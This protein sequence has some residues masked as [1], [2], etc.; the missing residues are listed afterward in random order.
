MEVGVADVAHQIAVGVVLVV[1]LGR[2]VVGPV[3]VAVAVGVDVE[4]VV[5]G[6]AVGV[7]RVRG[8]V[9]VA[10]LDAVDRVLRVV[11]TDAAVGVQVDVVLE[12]VA[13]VVEGRGQGRDR[14]RAVRGDRALGLG[15]R[16]AQH[17]H[18]ADVALAGLALGALVGV[19]DGVGVG[20]G[21]ERVDEQV[22]V[23]VELIDRRDLAHGPGVGLLGAV[24]DAVGVGVVVE[25]GL[26]AVV[27][28]IA[29]DVRRLLRFGRI[30]DLRLVRPLDRVVDAVGVGVEVVVVLGQVLVAVGRRA[31]RAAVVAAVARAVR[32]EGQ[33]GQLGGHLVAVLVRVE[34]AIGVGVVVEVVGHGVGV[35]VAG[36]VRP[37]DR[38]AGLAGVAVLVGHAAHVALVRVGDAVVVGVEVEEV[39]VAVGVGVGVGL[40][41]VGD[42]VVVRVAVLVV[43]GAVGPADLGGVVVVGLDVVEDA[44]TVGVVVEP[45]VDGVV[46]GTRHALGRV[47]GER[48]ALF[49]VEDAVAVGV[50]VE[51][52]EHAVAVA[53]ATQGGVERVV[54]LVALAAHGGQRAGPRAAVLVGVGDGVAVGVGVEPVL[55]RVAVAVVLRARAAQA[56]VRGLGGVLVLFVVEHAVAVGVDVLRVDVAVVVAVFVGPAQVGRQVDA[57]GR[58]VAHAG[59]AGRERGQRRAAVGVGAGLVGVGEAV[60]VGVVVDPVLVVVV[61]AVDARVADAAGQGR[62]APLLGAV[63][64]RGVAAAV[65]V[66]GVVGDAVVVRVEVEGVQQLVGG[67]AVEVAGV[68]AAAQAVVR[69][70]VVVVAR[71]VGVGDPVVVGVEI[72]PV[73]DAVGVDVLAAGLDRVAGDAVLVGVEDAVVVGVEVEG[74]ERTVAIGVGRDLA[75]VAHRAD[76]GQRVARGALVGRP[77]AR[78]AGR[79]VG[80][81]LVDVELAVAVGVV[82]VPALLAVGAGLEVGGQG[83]GADRAVPLDVVEHAVVV[84]VEVHGAEVR[85]TVKVLRDRRAARAVLRARE[86]GLVRIGDAV[87]VGVG[88]DPVLVGVGVAVVLGAARVADGRREL[89]GVLVL[90]VVEDPVAVGVVVLRVDLVVAVEVDLG[91]AGHGGHAAAALVRVGDAVAVGLEVDEGADAVAGAA[92]VA[93]VDLLDGVEDAVGVGVEILPVI[94]AVVVA[95]AGDSRAG[96]VFAR[97]GV[98]LADRHDVLDGVED[99]VAVHVV[100]DVVE[101]RVEVEVEVVVEVQA[102]LVVDAREVGDGVAVGVAVEPVPEVVVVDVVVAF[103]V[104]PDVVGVGVAVVV[105]QEAVAVTVVVERRRRVEVDVGVALGGQEIVLDEVGNFVA[106][107]VGVVAADE[108]RRGAVVEVLLGRTDGAEFGVVVARQRV[109]VQIGHAVVVVVEVALVAVA[110]AIVVDLRGVGVD[111]GLV[112][113]PRGGVGGAGAAVAHVADAV[114]V[115]VGLGVVLGGGRELSGH[116]GRADL[117]AEIDRLLVHADLQAGGRRGAVVAAV[118]QQVVV[119]VGLA[120]VAGQLAVVAVPAAAVAVAVDRVAASEA[121]HARAVLAAGRLVGHDERRGVLQVA[122]GV[123]RVLDADDRHGRVALVGRGRRVDQDVGVGARRIVEGRRRG[124]EAVIEDAGAGGVDA[125]EGERERAVGVHGHGR[126]DLRAGGGDVARL[127]SGAH[128]REVAV[129]LG[130]EDI[131]DA[132]VD[133]LVGNDHVAGGLGDAHVGRALL[134]DFVARGLVDRHFAGRVGG[135]VGR[136]LGGEDVDA[137]TDV[138]GVP[139]DR[140]PSARVHGDARGLLGLGGRRVD[141]ELVRGVAVG[142][143]PAREDAVAV[144]ARLVEG[145]PRHDEVARVVHGDIGRALRARRELVD[146]QLDADLG[147]RLVEAL[148]AD[149]LVVHAVGPH[150]DEAAVGVVR[151]GGDLRQLL[152]AGGSRRGE[153]AVVEVD[154]AAGVRVERVLSVQQAAD[155]DVLGAAL[156]AREGHRACAAGLVL[157][158][159][160]RA[161]GAGVVVDGLDRAIARDVEVEL[162]A[163]RGLVHEELGGVGRLVLVGRPRLVGRTPHVRRHGDR[164]R[165][166][167]DLRRCGR[168]LESVTGQPLRGEVVLGDVFGLRTGH[169]CQRHQRREQEALRTVPHR[170]P[171]KRSQVV[172]PFCK[173]RTGKASY[174]R[175]RSAATAFRGLV[176]LA[177]PGRRRT[178]FRPDNFRQAG[179]AATNEGSLS[180]FRSSPSFLILGSRTLR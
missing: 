112:G 130:E 18:A 120:H 25:P 11:A 30:L 28:D 10:G 16:V 146:G 141:A 32:A 178:F 13:V 3:L 69:R 165:G 33:R 17:A 123:L 158:G 172:P 105:V 101:E 148:G 174:V 41:G 100:V 59:V 173:M 161:D 138:R 45:G 88:V 110:V 5:L 68:G 170:F 152:V 92:V 36:Q 71:L 2:A 136:E 73:P 177:R 85:V 52:V 159:L 99:A 37:G 163:V 179:V 26:E 60:A 57:A 167:D 166:G 129:E 15:R 40:G 65:H 89:V 117:G 72:P 175:S 94:E 104:V 93:V 24:G 150:D 118:A 124:V 108:R 147:A 143:V 48:H 7:E 98:G 139:G 22:A 160:P 55:E 78:G 46:G 86:P 111:R 95:V 96:G 144:L 162:V 171:Q 75:A 140:E 168:D 91:A 113:D 82:V 142:V 119:G 90:G 157:A 126:G 61:V 81:G 29:R 66:L 27:V 35:E 116:E 70:V 79:A 125:R 128:D 47:F 84:G 67:A 12:A 169:E 180:W 53:V 80:A 8:R 83:A 21:V 34:D 56:D 49:A 74:A 51:G 77:V 50:G 132:G 39:H 103:D 62:E 106:V 64:G 127:A 20:V 151:R 6:V 133:A 107:G 122:G 149:V 114:A 58:R 154:V 131:G 63:L 1:V 4:V 145:L 23:G 121:A 97:A 43:L 31:A 54:V 76:R 135:A 109:F 14:A 134:A 156:F 38:V 164:R 155:E 87:A 137:F 115:G 176:P 44:V 9:G 153:L 102:V 19:D 42:A